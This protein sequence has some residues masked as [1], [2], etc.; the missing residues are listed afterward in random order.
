[1]PHPLTV[2]M[3]AVLAV[4]GSGAGIY[5]G[6]AAI[7]EINPA[8]YSEPETRFHADLTPYRPNISSA[9]VYRAGQL[10]PAELDQ[11]LGRGC[12]G[13]RTY[14][15]EY[16]PDQDPSIEPD[17]S[18]WAEAADQPV[19]HPAVYTPEAADEGR[20]ADF[21]AVERYTGYRVTTE[22]AGEETT[23]AVVELASAAESASD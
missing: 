21:A 23:E 11:A 8:Y 17:R 9:M 4:A 14:P 19:A 18:G 12:V 3:L 16:Y 10:S 1:M 7:S 20:A 15:E 13:C 22:P 6:R 2:P 5:L